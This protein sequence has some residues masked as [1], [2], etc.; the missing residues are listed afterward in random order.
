MADPI[1]VSAFKARCLS[2]LDDVA[3]TGEELVVTK[4]GEPLARVVPMEPPPPLLGSVRFT[5][6]DKEL[7]API[8][9]GWSVLDE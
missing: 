4:R 9:A 5:V 3:R 8:R 2:L 6:T 1:S 7:V